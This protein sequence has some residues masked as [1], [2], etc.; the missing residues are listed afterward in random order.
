MNSF[1]RDLWF[2]VRMSLKNPG[3]TLVAVLSLAV[4]IGVNSTVFGFVN[5]IFFKSISVPHSDN[6]VYVITGDR[7]NPY[8]STSYENYLHLRG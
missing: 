7:R 6:L 3:F 1:L 5:A 2:G 4:G 8:R